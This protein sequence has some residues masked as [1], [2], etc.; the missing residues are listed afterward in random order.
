MT[1]LRKRMLECLQL[2]SLSARTQEMVRQGRAPTGGAL[3]HIP[4]RDHRGSTP[5]VLPLPQTCPTVLPPCQ[6]H[7]A[8][9]DHVLLPPDPHQRLDPPHLCSPST[10]EEAA[11]DPQP[12]SGAQD[13]PLGATPPL[14]RVPY[15]DR[16][17]WSPPSGGD[18]SAGPRERERSQADPRPSW[19]RRA[20]SGRSPCH[21]ARWHGCATPG[22][23]SAIPCCS[24]RRRVMGAS[25]WR[26]P[27]RPCPPPVWRAL[28]G[29]LAQSVASTHSPL[30]IRCATPG[31]PIGLRRASLS[32]SFRRLSGPPLPPPRASP[33]P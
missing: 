4:R 24:S 16:L 5:T 23:R 27:Q 32:G 26:R 10:R 1:E 21:A 13:S 31:R 8:V 12:R 15:H 17:L 6:H 14:P 29:T 7:G 18:P 11:G 19:P 22:A 20:R 3:S 33:R 2:R 28:S 25:P 9:R 30:S